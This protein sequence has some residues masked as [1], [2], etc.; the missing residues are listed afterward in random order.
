MSFLIGEK[1]IRIGLYSAVLASFMAMYGCA[2]PTGG[3]K[4]EE[5]PKKEEKATDAK[6]Q[7][8]IS[9]ESVN[10]VGDGGTV[11]IST[12]GSVKY[13]VFKLSDPSRLVIDMPG[14]NIGKVLPSVKIDNKFL[15]EITSVSYGGENQI[16]RIILGLKNGTD[17]EVKSGENSIMVKLAATGAQG[18]AVAAA[19]AAPKEAPAAAQTAA[20]KKAANVTD[21]NVKQAANLTTVTVSSD[22]VIGNYNSFELDD[23][24]RVIIDVWGVTNTTGKESLNIN[25]KF[26]KVMRVGGHDDKMRLVFDSASKDLPPYLV[27]KEGNSLVVSFGP[28]V[29]AEKETTKAA[30]ADL[31]ESGAKPD[32]AGAAVKEAPAAAVALPPAPVVAAAVAV[33]AKAAPVKTETPVAAAEQKAVAPKGAEINDIAYRKV[34]GG[35][36]RLTIVSSVKPAYTVQKT[37]DEKAVIIDLKDVSIRED[38]VRTLDAT[39]LGTPVA[40]ISSF[41]ESDKPKV[42]RVLV[43]LGAQASSDVKEVNGTITIDFLP[44]ELAPAKPRKEEAAAPQF[45]GKAIDLDMVDANVSDVLRLIAEVSNLNIIASDDVRGTISLRLKNVPWDQAFDIILRAKSL[46][47]I[48]E[49]N[50]VRVAPADKI[51]QEKES[52]LSAKKAQEKLEDLVTKEYAVSYAVAADLETL[53]KSVLT[54]RGRTANDKRTNTLIITDIQS[55]VDRAIDFARKRDTPTPQVLIEARIVEAHTSFLRDIGIQ[56]GVDY[57]TGGKT[58]TTTFGSSTTAGQ[59]PPL[60]SS[61]VTNGTSNPIFTKNTAGGGQGSQNF[62]VNLPASG[63]IGPLGAL[64]FVVGKAGPNPLLLDLRLS[65][66]EQ[67]GQVRTISRPRVVTLDNKE[68]KIQQGESIPFSTTSASGTSTTF[69]D[70]NL[71]L[72][73]MPHITPDGS[74]SMKIKASKNAPGTFRTASGEPSIDKKESETEVLVKDGETTVIGGI[75]VSSKSETYNGIPLLMDIP[76]IGWI[77]KSQ[78]INDDQKE[79]LIFITPTIVKEKEKIP[80]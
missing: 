31:K 69:V 30:K 48:Q 52:V 7:A 77:F 8:K 76:I 71:S 6:R 4:G 72:T 22:G 32:A 57:A 25:D 65:A 14:V 67:E 13:T 16:G 24:S 79:L 26:V 39:K 62:A 68:A 40:A 42:V 60:F 1:R 23:P 27:K 56:W 44:A 80:G 50:V 3:M 12:T 34:N 74:V 64:G 54:E 53:V 47:K 17:Y 2:T 78:S 61:G 10:V 70:A 21:L 18:P 59:T 15:R 63:S 36:G 45:T 5:P 75:V 41:Q 73:V 37:A 43:K 51:R 11:L 28:G 33:P 38:L 19:S 46:D 58:S 55:A 20:A 9:V 49:G 66:G 35:K 29:L